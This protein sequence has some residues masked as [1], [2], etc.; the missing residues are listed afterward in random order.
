MTTQLT[1]PRLYRGRLIRWID[2]DTFDADICFTEAEVDLGFY[3]TAVTSEVKSRIRFRLYGYEAPEDSGSE[4]EM[5]LLATNASRGFCPEGTEITISSYKG[6]KYGRWLAD[7][8]VPGG[9]NLVKLLLSGGWGIPW[10]G[11]G[12][13]PTFSSDNYP[14]KS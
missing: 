12:A 4:R 1:V 5:G 6:D 13:R 7:V 3:I 8:M 2:G 9:L 10:D 11:K 14:I